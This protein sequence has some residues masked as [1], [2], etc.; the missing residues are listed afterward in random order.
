MLERLEI[1]LFWLI[2][3]FIRDVFGCQTNKCCA[4]K[5][6]TNKKDKPKNTGFPV[7]MQTG[8]QNSP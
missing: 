6:T 8:K 2:R 1:A 5:M 4:K 3:L 7:Y